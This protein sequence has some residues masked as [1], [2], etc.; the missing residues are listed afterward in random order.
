M[1]LTL[2]MSTEEISVQKLT[3]LHSEFALGLFTA[4]KIGIADMVMRNFSSLA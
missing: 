4:E 3:N 2:G 1:L